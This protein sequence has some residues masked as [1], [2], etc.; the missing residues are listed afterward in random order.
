MNVQDLKVSNFLFSSVI[1]VL[2]LASLWRMGF[3][4]QDMVSFG[5]QMS[6]R[7]RLTD[8]QEL[9]QYCNDLGN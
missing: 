5:Q 3:S 8:T 4:I 6:E 2:L 9:T 1:W 7:T